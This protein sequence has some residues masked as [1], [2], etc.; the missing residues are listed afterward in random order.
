MRFSRSPSW[1]ALGFR[2]SL[3]EGVCNRNLCI[4]P[5]NGKVQAGY[6]DLQHKGHSA[7]G[8][9]DYKDRV[10]KQVAWFGGCCSCPGKR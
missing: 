6:C 5:C 1:I 10:W 9:K 7:A 3:W 2:D 8:E 4:P